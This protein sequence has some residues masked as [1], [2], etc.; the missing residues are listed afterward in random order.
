MSTMLDM[1]GSFIIGGL[2]LIMILSYNT[3]FAN[4]TLED[5]FELSV[6]ENMVLLVE[7]MDFNF[8]KI[9]Y[10]VAN[11]WLSIVNGDTSGI[12]LRADVDNDGVIDVVNYQL[13][14]TDAAIGTENPNDR[15]LYSTLNGV[16]IGGT[17]GVT[18]F[19]VRYYDAGGNQVT[20]MTLV[21][22][23]EYEMTFESIMPVNSVYARSVWTG[24][25]YPRNLF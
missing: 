21:R 24:T 11:P 25:V 3:N 20:D 5:Q 14:T 4:M 22:Y 16:T 2:L 10:G 7:E 13:S 6:Q 8:R 18:D 17:F 1:L 15:I 19:Q 9:G 23:L 12:T